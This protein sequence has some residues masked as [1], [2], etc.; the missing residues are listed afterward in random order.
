VADILTESAPPAAG[1]GDLSQPS[2]EVAVMA[3]RYST[4][5]DVIKARMPELVKGAG[6]ALGENAPL[7]DNME[8]LTRA[9]QATLDLRTETYRGY[10]DKPSVVKGMNGDFLGQRGY[11]KTALTAPSIQE[12]MQ[13]LVGML[14]GGA[15]ALKSFTAGNLGI[16]SVYGLVPFDLNGVLAR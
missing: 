5:G 9:H 1:P 16:G 14:P 3:N 15:D 12:Q 7:N 13:Q 2:R 4:T 11:L 8:I 6:Y 10:T